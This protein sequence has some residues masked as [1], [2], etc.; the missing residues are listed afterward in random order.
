[1]GEN[2]SGEVV[3][4]VLVGGLLKHRGEAIGTYPSHL[5][6]RL[7]C[8]RFGMSEQVLKCGGSHQSLDVDRGP[9]LLRLL[10]W[11]IGARL[12]RG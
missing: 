2:R 12:S 11:R 8:Y 1:M 4:R 10:A 9:H 7:G 3:L 5:S 6:E